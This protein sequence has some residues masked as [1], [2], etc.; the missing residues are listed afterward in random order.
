MEVRPDGEGER[1][2]RRK[3]RKDKGGADKHRLW[4]NTDKHGYN[5]GKG[6]KPWWE[7]RNGDRVTRMTDGQ[8]GNGDDQMTVVD[9]ETEKTKRQ[10]CNRNDQQP[11][12]R[13]E[14]M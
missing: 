5:G 6:D 9:E 7:W 4:R 3:A 14:W 8:R 1:A 11:H 13:T 10:R 2:A 12:V